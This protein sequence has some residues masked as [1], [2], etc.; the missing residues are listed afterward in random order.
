MKIYPNR[1]SSF[2]FDVQELVSMNNS[3][4][5]K[6]S[7][8][9]T[10]NENVSPLMIEL[11]DNRGL[12]YL[13]ST[14][15]SPGFQPYAAE[16]FDVTGSPSQIAKYFYAVSPISAKSSDSFTSPIYGSSKYRSAKTPPYSGNSSGGNSS[17][18]SRGRLSLSPLSSI[19][20]L[21]RKQLSSPRMY[22]TP[23][24]GGEEVF[25]MDD[26]QVR[27]MS[28]GKNRRSSSSSSSSGKG[29][30]SSSSSSSKSVLFKKEICIA[31]EESGNCRYNSKCQVC[32]RHNYYEFDDSCFWLLMQ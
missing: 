26:I 4:M 11:D 13:Q 12:R 3:K 16:N 29:S 32:S 25:V 15:M 5:K 28:G 23:V 1:D 9:R 30:S 2:V 14:T 20:N 21:E 17:F 19:E 6:V 24:K 27:P 31:W 10:S 18:S 8:L 22:Q 7:K